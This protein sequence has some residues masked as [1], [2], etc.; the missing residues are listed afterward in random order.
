MTAALIRVLIVEDHA[1]LAANLA[2]YFT[3]SRYQLDFAMDGWQAMH[4]LSSAS[5]DVIVL[6]V[7]LPG[8]SGFEVCARMRTD[9]QVYT[10]VIMLTARDHIDDKSTGFFAGADDYLVKPFQ[11]KELELRIQSL[12]RRR[13]PVAAILQVADLQFDLQRQQ[14]FFKNQP[15]DL[16]P[17]AARILENLMR[18]HPRM[19]SYQQLA[20]DVWGSDTVDLHTLRTHVYALRKLLQKISGQSLIETLTGRGYRLKETE[21]A[22]ST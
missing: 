10:P 22:A 11:L 9:L 5:Y 16:P 4:L 19:L 6:D 3:E 14:V 15:V 17:I 12:Y 1:P 13:Q 18:T 8:L 20:R 2:D 7:M 21:K